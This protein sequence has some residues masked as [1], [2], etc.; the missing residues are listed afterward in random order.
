MAANCGKAAWVWGPSHEVR[1]K[2]NQLA[3]P[4]PTM[5][6]SHSPWSGVPRRIADRVGCI[7]SN[8]QFILL[9]LDFLLDEEN[10]KN[11]K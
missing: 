7:F 2:K 8:G 11:N 10:I 5:C 3:G 9:Q 1:W 4:H 6:C